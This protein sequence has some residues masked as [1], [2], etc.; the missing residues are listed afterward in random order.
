[1]KYYL[2]GCPKSGLHLLDALVQPL[3]LNPD[4]DWAGTYTGNSWTLER[5]PVERITN[6]LCYLPDNCRIK[7]HACFDEDLDLYLYLS[8]V[9]HIFI[10]R[11]LRDVAVSQA[12]H[13]MSDDDKLLRHPGKDEYRALGDFED[14]LGAVWHGLSHMAPVAAY[15]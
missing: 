13:I 6:A 2:N 8:G 5:A 9:A 15:A 1:M 3:T 14:V 10:F 11:D 4:A 12:H 7:G